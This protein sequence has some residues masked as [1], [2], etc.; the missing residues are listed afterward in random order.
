LA[1]Q[2]RENLGVLKSIEVE[3]V[4]KHNGCR[5]QRTGQGPSTGFIDPGHDAESSLAQ[6]PLV[7]PDVL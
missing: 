1:L 2:R 5:D 4:G 6:L 7:V 3:I